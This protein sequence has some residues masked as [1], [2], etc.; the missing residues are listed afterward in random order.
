MINKDFHYILTLMGFYRLPKEPTTYSMY[1]VKDR[2]T[3]VI[4]TRGFKTIE[5]LIP[6]VVECIFTQTTNTIHARGVEVGK[7]E[8]RDDLKNLLGICSHEEKL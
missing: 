1:R 4:S 5:E 3:V 2:F 6:Y 8:L 7:R